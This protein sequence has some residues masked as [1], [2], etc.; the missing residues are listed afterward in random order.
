MIKDIEKLVEFAVKNPWR[1]TYPS[2]LIRRF[3]SELISN[4]NMV[5]RISDGRGLIAAAVLV[6]KINNPANDACLEIIG[7][8]SDADTSEIFRELIVLAK[9]IIPMERSGFQMGVPDDSVITE[10][11][12][13]TQGLL[14]YF[15]T[16]TMR[17]SDLSASKA[18]IPVEVVT[19]TV[20]D[21]DQI[22]RV[23]CKSFAQNADTSIPNADTWKEGFFK[24]KSHFYIWQKHGQICGFANL[25][26]DL[27]DTSC[28]IRSMGVLAEERGHGIGEAL[29]NQCLKETVKL[30]FK[31]CHLSVAVANEKA[32][33]LYLRAGFKQTEKYSYYRVNRA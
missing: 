22:Y 33:G 1:P 13:K 15:D 19:A 26:E 24:S 2:A 16:F 18:V 12:F 25:I 20:E 27:Q 11:F 31:S 3:L 28:E 30:G 5:F 4:E 8:R 14:H 6:D 32:L 10:D 21:L 17:V 9:N 29:L 23:L 7:M